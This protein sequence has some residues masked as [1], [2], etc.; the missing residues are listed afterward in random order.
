MVYCYSFILILVTQ[1]DVIS[2]LIEHV[3]VTIKKGA[4]TGKVIVT[5]TNGITPQ[6]LTNYKI[7]SCSTG[8]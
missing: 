4:K 7:G 5:L 3:K 6:V 8:V 1:R 2:L